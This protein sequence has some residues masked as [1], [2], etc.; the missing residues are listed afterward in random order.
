MI[1]QIKHTH[2]HTQ[3]QA[4]TQAHAHRKEERAM[5]MEHTVGGGL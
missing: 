2:A 3:G 5:V 1:R 4:D